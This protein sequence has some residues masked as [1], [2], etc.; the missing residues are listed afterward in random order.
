MPCPSA[1]TPDPTLEA[2]RVLLTIGLSSFE[3]RF[4]FLFPPPSIT[5]LSPKN[6][7]RCPPKEQSLLCNVA[8]LPQSPAFT[9]WVKTSCSSALLNANNQYADWALGYQR[10]F[11]GSDSK[12]DFPLSMTS[13]FRL[14]YLPLCE[15]GNWKY[16]Q[17]FLQTVSYCCDS[18]QHPLNK[19]TD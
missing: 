17:Q 12:P 19:T 2:Q 16:P 1:D 5:V 15:S 11:N 4:F 9:W 18:T 13:L 8:C 6:P 3:E 10:S 7:P 14:C